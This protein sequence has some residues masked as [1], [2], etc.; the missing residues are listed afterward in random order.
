VTIIVDGDACPVKNEIIALARTHACQVLL[1]ASLA[2]DMPE[3]PGA[4]DIAIM[5]RTREGDIVITADYG[6]A[7]MVLGRKARVID[8]RGGRFTDQ[9]IDGLMARRHAN[10]QARRAGHR[11]KGPR[12]FL[13]ADR[14][15][16]IATLER[17]LIER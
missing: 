14:E 5:N 17:L 15:A 1:V 2:H 3:G 11:T 12:P 8:H 4:A 16:F 6:L 10:R 9:N 13:S 7:C